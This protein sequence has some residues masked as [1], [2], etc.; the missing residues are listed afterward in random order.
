MLIHAAGLA[1]RIRSVNGRAIALLTIAGVLGGA[2]SARAQATEPACAGA[3]SAAST[4]LMDAYRASG[5]L[6]ARQVDGRRGM[7]SSVAVQIPPLAFDG[8]GTSPTLPIGPCQTIQRFAFPAV[9]APRGATPSPFRYVE[10][11]WNT[12]GLPRGPGDA[13]VSPHF[14]FHFYLQPRGEFDHHTDCVSTN[15]RT[16]DPELTGFGQMRRFLELPPEAYVPGGY[17]PDTGS[18]IP[19]MGLH[20]LDGRF[21]YTVAAVDHHPTLIYGTFAGRVVFA[22][23]S[24]TLAT[25]QDAMAAPGQAISFPFR[26]P[27]RVRGGVPWP[28]RFVVRHLP[29][30][31]AFTAGFEGFEGFRRR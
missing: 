25:L 20:L 4:A 5:P 16:C 17:F 21:D 31:G 12:E 30:S 29:G 28:T 9:R 10:V 27:R 2:G 22:E 1:H 23:A 15:G 3:D 13:F 8:P 19:M 6:V 18:S 14:D 7:P 11:D 26:Q 24:V